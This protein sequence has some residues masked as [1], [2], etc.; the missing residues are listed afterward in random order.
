ME[1]DS[2]H[3]DIDTLQ[4]FRAHPNLLLIPKLRLSSV[5]KLYS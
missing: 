2:L 3:N 1:K 4:Q 5:L